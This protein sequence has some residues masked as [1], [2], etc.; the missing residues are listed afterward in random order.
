MSVKSELLLQH[1]VNLKP[2]HTFHMDVLASAFTTLE[3][4][5]QIPGMLKLINNR[6]G[7]F[8]FLG[9]GSNVLFAG[10]Y[11]G[12]VIRN[13]LKG[14][15]ILERDESFV[16]VRAM[17][18]EEWDDLVQFTVRHNFG[19]LENLTL[20]PGKVG[21]SPIQ[22]IGA[23]GVEMKDS[24]Y[25]LEAVS[26]RTGEFREFFRSECGFGY[27]NS[28]FK[29]ELKGQYF[30]ISVTFKLRIFPEPNTA[31]GSIAAELEKNGLQPSVQNVA[32]AVASIRRS[33]L[34]D[35][36][37]TGNAGSFF[38]NPVISENQFR[39]LKQRFPDIPSY[40]S[41]DGVKLAAG[42]LIEKCG[43]KGA[44]EGDAG[45]HQNQALVLVN[46]GNATGSQILG[47][48]NRIIYSVEQTFEVQLETEVN[49]LR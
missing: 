28:I 20:I 31:Y 1:N 32:Y 34:P 37:I 48:A 25:M 21:S 8:L 38:K 23:Y 26:L 27:R 49:I 9:G 11:D 39:Q 44:R 36:A 16:Y 35:P 33:K 40:P 45:V 22:N 47:L 24:F 5:S 17:G 42:W 13:C 43:W 46:H 30:I 6:K 15:E 14:I 7:K 12:L 4:E 19:G 3:A 10:D 41:T 2:F 29:Q 18:G